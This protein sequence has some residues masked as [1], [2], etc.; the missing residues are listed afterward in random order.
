MELGTVVK[1][2]PAN[3]GGTRECGSDSLV[4]KVPCGRKWQPTP[5]FLSPEPQEDSHASQCTK[6]HCVGQEVH[7]GFSITSYC[8][9]EL[10]LKGSTLVSG[11]P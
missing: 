5:I 7:L 6:S 1:I 11:E 10:Y 2:L 4:R 8:I 3:A 9:T